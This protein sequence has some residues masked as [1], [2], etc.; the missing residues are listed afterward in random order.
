LR[1]NRLAVVSL[2]IV[3]I[4]AGI[5]LAAPVIAPFAPRQ[6]LYFKEGSAVCEAYAPGRDHL[7]GVD[8]FCRDTFSRIVYGARISLTVGIFTQA[9]ALTLGV[10]VGGVAGLGGK[11]L[12]NIMMRFTDAT[13]AFPD[14][15]L[16]I[17]FASVFRETFLGTWA[18][19]IFAI[20]L[21]IGVAGWVTIARLVRGQIL[22]LKER[23]FVQAAEALGATRL[24]ILFRHL[25]PNTLSPVIVAVTFGIPAA[26]FAEAALSF[27]GVGIRPP[28]ASWGV[29]V[30]DG[31]QLILVSYWPIL[32]P[33][34]AIAITMLCFT[35]LG[36][37]LRDALDPRT[38]R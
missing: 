18:G 23:E 35:F 22:S 33:G 13:Y 5:A 34:L 10:V 38:R 31:Y 25:V 24:Q 12:D 26:I 8:Q 32:F 36:D 29:M 20:F 21:A 30:N 9:I 37:G 1:R 6:Q 3:V 4:M 7:F 15:L 28:T 2:V 14:L 19:G 16:I 27:I 11:L 17:L